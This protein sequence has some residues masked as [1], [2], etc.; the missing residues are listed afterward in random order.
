MSD[1]SGY[2]AAQL[3]ESLENGEID[4]LKDAG[5]LKPHEIDLLLSMYEH[6]DNCEDHPLYQKLLR[7][8]LS[9]NTQ[10][11]VKNGNVSQMQFATGFV[12]RDGIEATGYEKLVDICSP[13]AH[14]ILIKGP[15]GTGKSTKAIDLIREMYHEGVVEKVM[16]NIKGPDDHEDVEFAEDISRY[17]EFAKEPG[18]KVALFDEF[19][20]S[21]NAYTGQHD[22]EQIMGRVINAFR[23]SEGG[24]LRTIY[25]GHENDNDIHPLVKKQSDVVINA[26]G[27]ADENLIDRATVFRGWESYKKDD[28]WF[29]VRGLR[30][31][32]NRSIWSFDTNYFSHLGWDLDNPDMQIQRGQ[33]IEGWEQFQDGSDS[34]DEPDYERVK[35]RGV[36]DS[37]E[38]CNSI[39]SHESGFCQYHREQW[40]GDIDPRHD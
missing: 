23:K 8:Y 12:G 34:D 21:G 27:K 16:T 18:E 9:Q 13:A 28:E 10:E 14:Q 40:D 5:L 3:R 15:K 25:I 38:G 4:V 7:R 39:T 22:V 29:K 33:L 17:L 26:D 1:N 32:T 30:D 24:S 20:T 11:A 35:C 19:S 37:G 31:V 36:K 2:S 6:V